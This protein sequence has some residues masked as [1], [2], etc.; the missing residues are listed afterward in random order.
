M[1]NPLCGE[2]GAARVFGPQ[3]GATPAM[4]ERLDAGLQHLGTVVKEQL[5][6]DIVN[7][8]GAGAAGGLGGG[9]WRLPAGAR[10]G[11]RH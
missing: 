11:T 9:A 4:V 3:K 1:D 5:G 2:H 10:L 7:I 6:K 8:P